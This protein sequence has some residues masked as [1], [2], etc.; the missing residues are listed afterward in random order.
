MPGGMRCFPVQYRQITSVSLMLQR[1]QHQAAAIMACAGPDLIA[2]QAQRS[3]CRLDF[4]L[5]RKTFFRDMHRNGPSHLGVPGE[6]QAAAY[7]RA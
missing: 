6:E 2:S 7:W 1:F 3:S 4:I 5:R